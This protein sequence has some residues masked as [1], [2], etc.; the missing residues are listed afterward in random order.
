MVRTCDY[1]QEQKQKA[2]LWHKIL[3]TF[4]L[5]QQGYEEEER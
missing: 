4:L 2:L 1:K 3:S 5:G